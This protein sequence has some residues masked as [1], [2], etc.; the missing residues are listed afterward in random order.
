M[1]RIRILI[2]EDEPVIALDIEESLLALGYEVVAVVDCAEAALSAVRQVQPDLV[3]MDIHLRGEQDGIETAAKLRQQHCLPIVFLT[4][5]ADEATLSQAKQ[6][7][8]FGYIVKPFETRDLSVTIEVALSRY[9]AECS[10]QKLLAKEKELSALKTH[11]VS[12]ISHEFR[13]P[14]SSILFSLDLL[15]YP[16]QKLPSDKQQA[17]LNR[18]RNAVENMMQLLEDVLGLNEMDAKSLKCQPAPVLIV[19]FCQELVEQLQSHPQTHHFIC[20]QSI[21]FDES[22]EPQLYVL[23][24][25]LL[26]RIL[27][28]L[29][30]N[31]IKYSPG[32]SNI[33]FD[34]ICDEES[35]IFRIRDQGIG[36]PCSDQACLFSPFYRGENVGNIPGTGLGLSIVKQCVEAHQGRIAVESE[37]G[38]GTTFIISIGKQPAKLSHTHA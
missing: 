7:Q 12:L 36:I 30:S 15:Q 32:G 24:E 31:A 14:L 33:Q 8:P 2:V 3:L 28:N 25:R 21:G 9:Q 23:D 13:N 17:C 27:I 5:H 35:L 18:A 1:T 22:N 10:I 19:D 38:K 20:F 37:I 29:L 34:L 11:F 6:I 4:A 16:P 26:H